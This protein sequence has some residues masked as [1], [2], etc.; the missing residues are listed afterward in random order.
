[1]IGEVVRFDDCLFLSCS[2][3]GCLIQ[4]AGGVCEWHDC[5]FSNCRI[6]LDGDSENALRVLQALGI[7]L[8]PP[9]TKFQEDR[10]EVLFLSEA[11]RDEKQSWGFRQLEI[12]R[13]QMSTNER[14]KGRTLRPGLWVVAVAAIR[15]LPAS[16]G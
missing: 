16:S 15:P 7:R 11:L 2:F 4:Y 13:A 12:Q 1:M 3:E 6:T 10:A 9:L 14:K 8:I 5:R